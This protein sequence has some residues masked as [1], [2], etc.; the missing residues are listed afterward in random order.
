MK[1]NSVRLDSEKPYNNE[2]LRKLKQKTFFK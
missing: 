2:K 1:K